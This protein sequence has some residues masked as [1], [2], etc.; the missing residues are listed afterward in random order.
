[1][2]ADV[3]LLLVAVVWG[4]SYITAKTV[5]SVYPVFLFLFIRFTLTVVLMA[6]FTLRNLRSFSR[7]TWVTGGIFGV[8]LFTI[9]SFETIGIAYTSASNAAFLISLCVVLCPLVEG[10]VFRKAPGWLFMGAVLLSVIGTG[11][12]TMNGEGYHFNYGDLMILGAA[13]MRAVQMTFTQK[14][15]MG[16]NLDSKALTTIQL[17]VVAILTGGVS[18]A[19]YPSSELVFPVS[20]QFWLITLYLAVFCTIFAFYVQMAMIRRTSPSRVGLL[21]G[22]EPVF[23][24]I[25][26][27]LLGGELMTSQKILGGALIVLATFWGRTIE[28]KRRMATLSS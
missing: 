19:A 13:L 23:G 16:K 3:L 11:L 20:A 15:T 27:V 4:S 25:F 2:I 21:M 18:L 12:L 8:M 24:A 28:E 22:T 7:D 5:L 17:G 1:M 9:F 10:V 6:P 26:A 14:L